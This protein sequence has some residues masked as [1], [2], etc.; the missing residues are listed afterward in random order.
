[1]FVPRLFRNA[2][3][4]FY[5]SRVHEQIFSS[6]LVRAEE[7]G[8][9]TAMGTAQILHHGYSSELVRT[10]RKTERNLRLLEQAVREVPS[11]ANLLMNLG[12]ELSRCDR[13]DEGLARYEEAFAALSSN[14]D[15]QQVPELREALLT[16]F[17]SQLMRARRFDDVVRVLHSP[18]ARL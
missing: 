10:R 5:I 3:G 14:P 6:I 7:W 8:L 4:L 11:D 18:V 16:Q 13:F 12:L 2:P 15:Q 1:S 9:E 17:T